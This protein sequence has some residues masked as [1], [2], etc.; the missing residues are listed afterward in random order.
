MPN[1]TNIEALRHCVYSDL[2]DRLPVASVGQTRSFMAN[3]CLPSQA[4]KRFLMLRV[5][6]EI[7][8]TG[9]RGLGR[10]LLIDHL[11]AKYGERLAGVSGFYRNAY[12][13][14]MLNL[15][16]G[17]ALYGYRS[18]LGFYNGILCQPL[19]EMDTFFLL[20]SVRMGGPTAIR[21]TEADEAF[22][23]TGAA[24]TKTPLL[25]RRGGGVLADGVVDSTRAGRQVGR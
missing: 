23:R 15:P 5:S 1:E 8:E 17:C 13:R 7:G 6:P 16:R 3:L 2:L 14:L 22:F 18:R 10:E 11:A 21:M 24:A 19:E 9:R 4:I 25:D 12:G 20:S